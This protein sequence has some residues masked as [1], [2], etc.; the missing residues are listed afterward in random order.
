MSK[1]FIKILIIFASALL[2]VHIYTIVDKHLD[3][4]I[5]NKDDVQKVENIDNIVISEVDFRNHKFMMIET[6]NG[7][8]YDCTLVHSPNCHCLN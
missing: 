1:Y 3:V 8:D 5:I 4:R 6:V 2:T 7:I